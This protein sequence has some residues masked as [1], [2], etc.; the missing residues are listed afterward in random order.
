PIMRIFPLF[1][2]IKIDPLIESDF[3]VL[4]ILGQ[5]VFTH[6]DPISVLLLNIGI[7]DG[8]SSP[9]FSSG[10]FAFLV[11]KNEL[12][13]TIDLVSGRKKKKRPKKFHSSRENVR[14]IIIR[15]QQIVS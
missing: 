3:V 11:G 6:C 2:I 10:N 15:T 7:D 4:G 8:K 12:L 13:D 1:S 14:N 9:C 5:N